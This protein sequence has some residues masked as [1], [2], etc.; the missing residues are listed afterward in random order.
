MLNRLLRRLRRFFRKSS[1]VNNE[2]INKVSLG[3]I[4]L[5]DI[6]ILVNVFIGLNDISQ[7]P[8]SPNQEYGCYLTWN[9]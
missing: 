8:I 9:S 3:V 2:P 5:I 4:I 1:T 7:W 6:F